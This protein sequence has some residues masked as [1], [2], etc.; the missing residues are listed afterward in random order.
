MG[1]TLTQM[2][3]LPSRPQRGTVDAGKVTLPSALFP[4]ED[5]DKTHPELEAA[6]VHHLQETRLWEGT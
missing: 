5:M 2:A 1:L 6:K 3:V 4:P